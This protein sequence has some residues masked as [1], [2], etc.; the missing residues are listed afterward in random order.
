MICE[1]IHKQPPYYFQVMFSY[2]LRIVSLAILLLNLYKP[3][4]VSNS[5]PLWKTLLVNQLDIMMSKPELRMKKCIF[6]LSRRSP[7][8]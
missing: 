4:G 2:S 7:T 6:G 8:K 3:F 1:S 5:R